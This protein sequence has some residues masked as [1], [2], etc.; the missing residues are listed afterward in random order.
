MAFPKASSSGLESRTRSTMGL[1]LLLDFEMEVES[2]DVDVDDVVPCTDAKCDMRILTVS[3]FPAPDS[4]DTSM[5]WSWP[6]AASPRY[7]SEDVSYT[8]GSTPDFGSTSFG[9]D[10]IDIGNE[11]SMVQYK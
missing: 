4:P 7:A 9:A 3:V 11:I 6:S 10:G 1:T 2:S 8:C 5:D